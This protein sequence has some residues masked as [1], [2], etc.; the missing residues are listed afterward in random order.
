[1]RGCTRWASA[2]VTTIGRR[3]AELPLRR[4]RVRETL[5]TTGTTGDRCLAPRPDTEPAAALRRRR[6]RHGEASLYNANLAGAKLSTAN[7]HWAFLEGADL[8]VD[9]IHAQRL[10]QDQLSTAFGDAQ[11][12]LPFGLIR[13]KSWASRDRVSGSAR[14]FGHPQP[15]A[16]KAGTP[17]SGGGC[18]EKA[19]IHTDPRAGPADGPVPAHRGCRHHRPRHLRG[20]VRVRDQR[21]L[22]ELH[23]VQPADPG[24]VQRSG[25]LHPDGPGPGPLRRH[26]G[27][28]QLRHHNHPPC[29]PGWPATPGS[30]CT[31]PRPRGRG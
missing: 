12:R 21:H 8:G 10:T 26:V 7:L 29:G 19:R 11:T 2:A 22:A 6:R 17:G 9:L 23:R 13:P 27:R 28:G 3:T 24:R 31:S 14:S 18:T 30:P 1:M 20:A 25:Q 4:T 15:G 16:R 5:T